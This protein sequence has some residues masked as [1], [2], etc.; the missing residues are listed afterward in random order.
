MY[1]PDGADAPLCG[2]CLDRF[3]DEE[4]PPWWPNELQRWEL[5]VES[6]FRCQLRR[7]P[8]I[9]AAICDRIAA[10]VASPWVP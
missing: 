3:I 4:G 10:F 1:I 9:P 8:P 2:T 7:E 6:L 5:L